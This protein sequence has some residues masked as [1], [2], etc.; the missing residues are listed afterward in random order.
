ML[1]SALLRPIRCGTHA[2]AR[3]LSS[4]TAGFPKPWFLDAEPTSVTSSVT[5]P[6]VNG[7]QVSASQGVIIETAILPPDLPEHLHELHAELVKL[8][9]LEPGRLEI[10]PP[11]DTPPGPPLPFTLPRGRRRRGGTDAGVGVPVPESSLWK[12]IVLAQVSEHI[13][14]YLI[15]HD[16]SCI[17]YYCAHVF[18]LP[19][20]RGY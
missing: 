11:L 8:P 1:R 14:Y 15:D 10:R 20:K 19:G 4:S 3:C 13:F 7:H 12:W 6:N 16:N 2:Q 9:L 5:R 17:S 18:A